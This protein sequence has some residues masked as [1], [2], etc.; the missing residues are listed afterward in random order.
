MQTLMVISRAVPGRE[1]EFNTWYQDVHVPDMLAIDG[2]KSCA[3]QR[4]LSSNG[5][6]PEHAEFV[7]LYEIDGDA[8]AV[9]GEMT[10]RIRDGRAALSDTMDPTGAKISVW[11]PI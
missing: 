4:L 3:R 2:V 7:A 6:P 9:L 11:E 10:A 1:D 5:K 8:Q